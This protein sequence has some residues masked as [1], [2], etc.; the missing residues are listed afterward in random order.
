MPKPST[1]IEGPLLNN[2]YVHP[3]TQT[4]Y[5]T[6]GE[7]FV[8][9]I[10]QCVDTKNVTQQNVSAHLLNALSHSKEQFFTAISQYS[11]RH[12]IIFGTPSAPNIVTDA[13]GMRSV[14]YAG[15]GGIVSSHALLVE[16]AIGENIL[17]DKLPFQYGY[18]GNRTPFLRTKILTP[19]TYYDIAQN[20]LHRFWPTAAPTERSTDDVAAEILQAATTAML[21]VSRNRPLKMALTAGLDSRVILAVGINAG[22][23]FETYTYGDAENT[24]RDRAFAS[25][26]A[27]RFGI[28]HTTVPRVPLS[29]ALDQRLSEVTYSPH[30]KGV[31]GGLMRFFDNPHSIA[32]TGNLLEIGRSFYLGRRKEGLA[33]PVTAEAMT[34][35][36]FRAM[37]AN[38]RRIIEEYGA[39]RYSDVAKIAFQLFIEETKLDRCAAFLDGFDQFYWEHRMATWHGPALAERDFYA[40][41]FIPFN[42]RDVFAAMLSVKRD[43][44]DTSSTFYRLIEMV[45]PHLLDLPVNPSKWPSKQTTGKN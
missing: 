40:E 29:K 2:F 23:D 37:S 11:G 4:Q 12:A 18:P 43:E 32:V 1:Y 34:K 24:A 26:L 8:L 10:G 5:S 33:Q 20:S 39:D 16:N 9:V 27:G 14:F 35:L 31:T 6:R 22:I 38:S 41:A 17:R 3:W 42:S 13:T 28:D 45:D 15:Q 19:N 25:D 30:H 36:H 44:R 7:L 21:N